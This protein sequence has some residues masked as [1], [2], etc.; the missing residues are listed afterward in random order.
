MNEDVFQARFGLVPR[1]FREGADGAL[2]GRA[3]HTGNS[4]RMPEHGRGLDTGRATY[5]TRDFVDTIA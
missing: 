1:K 3:I 2:Q 4:Q 5:V